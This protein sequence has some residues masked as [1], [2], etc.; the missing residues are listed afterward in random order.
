MS[1]SL[2]ALKLVTGP[3]LLALATLLGL[4][5]VGCST[6]QDDLARS[7]RAFERA[8]YERALAIFRSLEPDMTDRSTFRSKPSTPICAA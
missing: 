3:A 1:A 5:S 8:D 2:R 6:Y 7:Q 4:A